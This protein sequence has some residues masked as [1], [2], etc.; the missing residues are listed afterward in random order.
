MER[1]VIKRAVGR[2]EE[3]WQLCDQQNK[4]GLKRETAAAV[5]IRASF[6]TET[7]TSSGC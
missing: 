7:L 4:V 6:V 5:M 2:G 3:K 1:K